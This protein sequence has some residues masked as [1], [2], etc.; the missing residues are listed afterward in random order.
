MSDKPFTLVIPSRNQQRL[1]LTAQLWG[2]GLAD[3][4]TP[5]HPCIPLIGAPNI[6]LAYNSALAKVET[7]YAIFSHDDAAP[8]TYPKYFCGQRLL[9]R[10]R[11]VDILGFCGS[12]KFTGSSWQ[13]SGSLYG[14][15]INHPPVPDA[16]DPNT[17]AAIQ[18]GMRQCSVAV[19]QRPGR[20]IRGIRVADGYCIVART[21][22]LK[23]IGGFWV[24][25]SAP[26]YHHYDLDLF[27]RASEAGL[28]TAIASDVYISHASHGSYIQPEWAAGVPEFFGKYKGKADPGLGIQSVHASVHCGDSRIA[29]LYLLEQERH[30]HEEII[31]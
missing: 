31:L 5:D 25:E 7:E 10:M 6:A 13:S 17:L 8:L 1:Q 18:S 19:W 2:R 23:K 30:M 11:E 26:H 24:P 12:D 16:I 14:Q 21:E 22:A 28:R 3:L 4:G 15:V 9:E 20:L 29:Y 27:L